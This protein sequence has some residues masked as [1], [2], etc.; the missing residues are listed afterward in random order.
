MQDDNSIYVPAPKTQITSLERY[1][2]KN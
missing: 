1:H 2:N